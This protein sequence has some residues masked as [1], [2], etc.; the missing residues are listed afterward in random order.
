MTEELFDAEEYL[1]KHGQD[2]DRKI[3]TPMW[4]REDGEDRVE[5]PRQPSQTDVLVRQASALLETLSKTE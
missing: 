1:R 3:L 5:E 4:Q 2:L